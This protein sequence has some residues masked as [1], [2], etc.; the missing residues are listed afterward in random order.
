MEK[1]VWGGLFWSILRLFN[2]SS[3]WKRDALKGILKRK[4]D[5]PKFFKK[6]KENKT[7]NIWYVFDFISFIALSTLPKSPNSL[8]KFS[9]AQ[10]K[11]TER[12]PLVNKTSKTKESVWKHVGFKES[13]SSIKATL[14]SSCQNKLVQYWPKKERKE[15]AIMILAIIEVRLRQVQKHVDQ[16]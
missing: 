15:E 8:H 12:E 14:E 9:L 3:F 2:I 11:M 7:W 10:N 6:K 16:G 13:K 1:K 5:F 4:W